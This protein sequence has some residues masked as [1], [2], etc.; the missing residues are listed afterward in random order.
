VEPACG[1]ALSAIYARAEPLVE[2][3]PIVVIVCGGAGVSLEL[4]DV[5]KKKVT[6]QTY[7]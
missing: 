5:W 2:Y 3:D 1:A 7:L 6:D 4:M